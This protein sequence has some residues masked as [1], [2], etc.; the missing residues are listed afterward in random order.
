MTRF[1]T[2]FLASA[3]LLAGLSLK[4]D[5]LY[6]MVDAE[7]ADAFPF[8]YASVASSAGGYLTYVNDE[9]EPVPG[10]YEFGRESVTDGEGVYVA[11]AG[12][13]SEKFRV[14]LFNATG[15][16]L[17]YSDVWW[18]Y[19]DLMDIQAIVEP[20]A[21]RDRQTPWGGGTFTSAGAVPEP[22]SGLLMLMGLAGLMLRRRC[23]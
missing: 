19:A 16:P 11:I 7:A 9:G 18:S 8:A 15:S 1:G 10:V 6:W 13:E 23:A 20:M 4:G 17:A 12:R 21:E 2:Y 3:L 5:V 14:E 22:T